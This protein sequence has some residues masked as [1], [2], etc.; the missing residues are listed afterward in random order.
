[1]SQVL[2][3]TFD[4]NPVTSIDTVRMFENYERLHCYSESKSFF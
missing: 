2:L 1:M 4:L 3:E